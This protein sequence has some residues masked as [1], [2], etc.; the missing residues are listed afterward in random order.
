M[1][2][3]FKLLKLL[4]WE[5]CQGELLWDRD[6]SFRAKARINIRQ[7]VVDVSLYIDMEDHHYSSKVKWTSSQIHVIKHPLLYSRP[8]TSR[9][10]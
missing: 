6:L 8:L 2:D 7:L 1:N 5:D 9:Y 10:S 3:D 4:R